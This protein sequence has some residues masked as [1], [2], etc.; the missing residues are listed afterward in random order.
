LNAHLP[1][2]YL[3]VGAYSIP[4][5]AT[6]LR[7]KPSNIRRW[8]NGYS[9]G[10]GNEKRTLPPLWRI[11]LPKY[12]DHVEIGFKDLIE[13]KFVLAFMD[14]GIKIQTIRRCLQEASKILGDDHPFS[15]RRFKTDGKSIFLSSIDTEGKKSLLNLRNKQFVFERI[16]QQTFKDLDVE[17]GTVTS[18][19]PFQGKKS[20]VVDPKRSFGQPIVKQSGIPTKVLMDA[21]VA[22]KNV[23]SVA[24]FYEVSLQEVKDAVAFEESLLAA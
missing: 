24:R 4:E 18:W 12:G 5:A 23:K 20:I 13:L 10:V 1:I 21:M 14:Q 6:L 19:R 11:Q 8:L 15:T 3:S 2:D 22:E 16:V 7:A 17:S 9:F